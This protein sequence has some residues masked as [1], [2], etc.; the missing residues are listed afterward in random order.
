MILIQFIVINMIHSLW[1]KDSF[2]LLPLVTLI[3]KM[4]MTFGH[5]W[6]CSRQWIECFQF[7]YYQHVVFD[8]LL[9]YLKAFQFHLPPSCFD[10]AVPLALILLWYRLSLQAL[11]FDHWYIISTLLDLLRIVRLFLNLG[12][13][14]L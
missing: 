6:T 3:N 11:L 13:G 14:I 1:M 5:I 8:Y 2:C 4:I 9:L 7:H 10:F 12:K